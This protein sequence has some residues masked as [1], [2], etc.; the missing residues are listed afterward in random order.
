MNIQ[1]AL[2]NNRLCKALTGMTPSEINNLL[3]TFDEILL[4]LSKSKKRIRKAGGGRKGVLKSN[5]HKLFYILFY[6]KIYPTFDL[7]G[8]IF[9]VD[10]SKTHRWTKKLFPILEKTLGRNLVLP[11]RKITTTE[12]LLEYFPEAKEIFID[13]TERRIILEKRNAILEKI[14]LSVIKEKEILYLSPTTNGKRHDFNITK[15]EGLPQAISSDINTYLDMGFQGIKKLVKNPDQ[16]LMPKKKTK[17]IKLTPD[18]KE[19]NSI[20]SSIRIK[21]E[22]AIGGIKRFNCLSHI[23]RN[24]KGQDDKLIYLTTG[25]WNYHLRMGL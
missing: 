15:N 24:R 4:I 10:R 22:H 13:G 5:I 1:R 25:L 3:I 6:L 2:K 21:V 17:N 11:K 9:D 12:E 7:S 20:I 23:Y 14:S 18:E 16:I 19:T 8:F